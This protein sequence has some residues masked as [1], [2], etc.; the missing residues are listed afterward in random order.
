[1]EL[2]RIL[3]TDTEDTMDIDKVNIDFL[4]IDVDLGSI[5]SYH[6]CR[7]LL[8][9]LVKISEEYSKHGSKLWDE[10]KM[11]HLMSKLF[12]ECVVKFRHNGNLGCLYIIFME[13]M[14]DYLQNEDQ[15]NLLKVFQKNAGEPMVAY[16]YATLS[17]L[18][19]FVEDN[20]MICRL[21]PKILSFLLYKGK[22]YW[23]VLG[24]K[25]FGMTFRCLCISNNHSSLSIELFQ[26]LMS[27]PFKD[28]QNNFNYI[29]KLLKGEK[30]SLSEIHLKLSWNRFL[31]LMRASLL[32]NSMTDEKNDVANATIRMI[33]ILLMNE[34]KD[35]EACQMQPKINSSRL[36]DVLCIMLLKLSEDILSPRPVDENI[37]SLIRN[38]FTILNVLIKDDF[39]IKYK[40]QL[41]IMN[42]LD[43][44]MENQKEGFTS[45]IMAYIKF[46][47]NIS[48]VCGNGSS[49]LFVYGICDKII[50]R[51]GTSREFIEKSIRAEFFFILKYLSETRSR[52]DTPRLQTFKI[53]QFLLLVHRNFVNLTLFCREEA[54]SI[55]SF[56]D[57]KEL[58]ENEKYFMLE[59]L[60]ASI[61]CNFKL[62]ISIPD[63]CIDIL[64]SMTP[65][66][67][68]LMLHKVNCML[69]LCTECRFEKL[70]NWIMRH[71]LESKRDLLLEI[72]RFYNIKKKIVMKGRSISSERCIIIISDILCTSLNLKYFMDVEVVFDFIRCIYMEMSQ[73][74]VFDL[75]QTSNENQTFIHL[76]KLTIIARIKDIRNDLIA[77]IEHA[78]FKT[79]ITSEKYGDDNCI[80]CNTRPKT[81]L[82][83]DCNHICVCQ[84]C[85]QKIEKC[86]VCR[87]NVDKTEKI[88]IV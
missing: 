81:I 16:L 34:L 26:I 24:P 9:N 75:F 27:T 48:L 54:S 2:S 1:M 53:V 56:I 11:Y 32:P 17:E 85:S 45:N 4:S 67:I 35:A 7:S 28:I 5:T 69:E 13:T 39:V 60:F 84:D 76:K 40:M 58:T 79:M 68:D 57:I 6:L 87:Q 63:I 86:P 49:L 44:Y 30:I 50:S 8:E 20:A 10:K 3:N 19:T 42:S 41:K 71:C 52:K 31:H 74:Q 80:V 36:T 22:K 37:T 73:K 64:T 14:F 25:F 29:L 51:R 21:L 15:E 82:L 77:D 88:F 61:N 38:I 66:H 78:I 72:I 70:L 47:E 18:Y 62:C 46:L 43:I 65:D 12:S 33:N 83:K 55:L 59:L 23:H